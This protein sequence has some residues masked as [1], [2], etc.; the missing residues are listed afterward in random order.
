MSIIPW[1]KNKGVSYSVVS[2][3]C[4]PTNCS[5]PG[6]SVHGILQ[7]RILACVVI[8]FSRGC[9]SPRDQTHVSCTT[10]IFL[11][12]WATRETLA[13]IVQSL[14]NVQVFVTLWAAAH[15]ASLSFTVSW[16]L[17]RFMSVESVMLSNHLIL[18]LSL[19]LPS[20]FPSIRVFS[21]ESALLIR[22]QK[23]RPYVT[24][25][26]TSHIGQSGASTL[27]LSF[28]FFFFK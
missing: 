16:S 14:S 9:S 4:D 7:A 22:T 12:I 8:P 3:L 18:C 11:T 1:K 15:Q 6:S 25:N 19:L 17:L 27:C 28:F 26:D 20:I 10:D 24:L 2:I 5:L 21:S 23:Y 13:V